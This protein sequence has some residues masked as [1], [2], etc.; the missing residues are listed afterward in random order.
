[1]DDGSPEA[2][3]LR[4][5]FKLMTAYVERLY[6]VEHDYTSFGEINNKIGVLFQVITPA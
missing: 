2:E 3:H 6:N 5:I 1:V 4:L